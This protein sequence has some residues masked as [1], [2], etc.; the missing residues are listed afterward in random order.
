MGF[1]DLISP[2]NQAVNQNKAKRPTAPKLTPKTTTAAPK[3]T[4]P[5]IRV[6]Q[7]D[8]V[9]DNVYTRQMRQQT[10]QDVNRGERR[11]EEPQNPVTGFLQA[12]ANVNPFAPAQA[13][14]DE[15]KEGS[16]DKED[17]KPEK[18]KDKKNVKNGNKQNQAI[19][20]LEIQQKIDSGELQINDDAEIRQVPVSEWVEKPPLTNPNVDNK[21][22]IGFLG[23]ATNAAVMPEDKVDPRPEY[24]VDPRTLASIYSVDPSP[25]TKSYGNDAAEAQIQTL[26]NGGTVIPDDK[27]PDSA[28]KSESPEDADRRALGFYDENWSQAQSYYDYLEDAAVKEAVAKYGQEFVDPETGYGALLA[29]R[30]K[31]LWDYL[32]YGDDGIQDWKELYRLSGVDTADK[33]NRV[34]NLMHY[35]Y[36]DAVDLSRLY[37]DDYMSTMYGMTDPRMMS[38]IYR[39]AQN[40]DD[41]GIG[42]TEDQLKSMG[43]DAQSNP[44][45]AN[46]L[47]QLALGI[48]A[49]NLGAEGLDMNEVNRV[50]GLA[51][52]ELEFGRGTKDQRFGDASLTDSRLKS[53]K[54]RNYSWN[55][56][57]GDPG[58]V[59]LNQWEGRLLD[60]DWIDTILNA[61]EADQKTTGQ[62]GLQKRG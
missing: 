16:E 9:P 38:E 10:G 43:F 40:Q 5:A 4:T 1:M 53:G 59:N 37:D 50:M 35:L 29:S 44:F 41:Y 47:V 14:A 62:V 24:D 26:L 13:G 33:K 22:P 11:Q 30:N 32:V 19:L 27:K 2:V 23:A 60:R 39:W 3:T 58:K 51:G 15:A 55:D 21:G 8:N 56:I 61:Y 25:F 6:Y 12:V 49:S 18:E 52:D 48:R 7:N 20:P 54:A 42:F 57:T 45:D 28:K 46:D 34:D 17:K 36:D 31:D